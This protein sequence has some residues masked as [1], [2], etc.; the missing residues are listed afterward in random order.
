MVSKLDKSKKIFPSEQLSLVK[1]VEDASKAKKKRT[2][3]LISLFLCI[4]L[5]IIFATYR[6]INRIISE[7]KYPKIEL[8]FK[9]PSFK[10]AP[11][12]NIDLDPEVSPIL[13]NQDGLWSF[14]VETLPK[15]EKSFSWS[16]NR[17]QLFINSNPF[18]V[19]S[20]L[21]KKEDNPN[22]LIKSNL[23]EGTLIRENQ[24]TKDNYF[25][26]Q[27]I[28]TVPGKQIFLVIKTSGTSNPEKSKSLI[29]LLTE[30]IYWAVT[31]I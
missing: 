12:V 31:K 18:D 6:T 20:E 1:P 17:D 9:V 13:Q 15:N 14:Y 29:P 2:T 19:S 23:P 24:I 27:S 21:L 26:Y 16:K 5:S 7:K 10:P 8:N 25:E 4:G 3:L 11:V 22:S 28:I 30:K